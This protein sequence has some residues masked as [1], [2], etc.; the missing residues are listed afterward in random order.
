MELFPPI[1]YSGWSDT[2]PTLHRFA[3]I[4]GKVRLAASPRRT[5]DGTCPSTGCGITTRPMGLDPTFAIDFDFVEHQLV[6]NSIDGRSVSFPIGGHSVAT[7]H[8]EVVHAMQ[9]SASTRSASPA[10]A[11]STCRSR[12][13]LAGTLGR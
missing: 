8:A 7:F 2:I 3:Q 6:V 12:S 5:T 1:P 4:I 13:S 9:L 10:L 11:H